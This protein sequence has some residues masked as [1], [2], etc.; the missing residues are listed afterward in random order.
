MTKILIKSAKILNQGSSH[1]GKVRDVLI[2][3]D[4]IVKIGK[5]DDK[6]DRVIEAKGKILSLGWFDMRAW[7]ADPGFEH[8][9]DIASG[10]EAA[11]DGG[12]TGVALL[13]NN[14]P[15]TQSKNDISYLRSGNSTSLTQIYPIAAITQDTKGEELTEM[16]DLHTAGAVAFSDGLKPIWHS[17]ILLKTLQYLQKFDG[18]LIDRPEDIHLNM[19][20]VMNEGISSTMLGM[21]GMPTL[22]EELIVQRNLDILAYAGGRLHMSCVSSEKSLSLIRAARKKGLKITCDIAAYQ[23]AFDDSALKDFDTAYKVNPPFR[24]VA[25]NK[26]L[27]K[28]LQDGSIDVI[29]SGHIPHDEESK[30]LEFDLADFGIISLQTV[31]ANITSLSEKVEMELLIEKLTTNPKMLLKLQ[32]NHIEEGENAN[33]TLFDPNHEWVLDN[34]T[35]KSKSVNSPYWKMPL[36]GKAVA[37]FNNGLHNIS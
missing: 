22:A 25:E 13:P 6:A 24:T 18:L 19:F 35:N 5:I 37:V 10:R 23:T 20:G 34:K 21:K 2:D 30:K 26:A 14:K 4:K 1:H 15:V 31:A 27:I 7:F 29:V 32:I 9:E 17:D 11:M 8:K 33:L 3:K 12:F 28:G 16:I 36:K